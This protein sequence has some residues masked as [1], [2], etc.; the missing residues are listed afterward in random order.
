[1]D[2]VCGALVSATRKWEEMNDVLHSPAP[3][4]I[5]KVV[6]KLFETRRAIV[7]PREIATTKNYPIISYAGLEDIRF[8]QKM[9]TTNHGRTL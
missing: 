9:P 4:I 1:M 3:K 6:S 5:V 7:L 2:H 8:F